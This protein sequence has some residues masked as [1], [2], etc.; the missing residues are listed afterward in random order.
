[1][2]MRRWRQVGTA[3]PFLLG[4]GVGLVPVALFIPASLVRAPGAASFLETVTIWLFLFGVLPA[5][6]ILSLVSFRVPRCLYSTLGLWMAVV[7]TPLVLIIYVVIWITFFASAQDR[8]WV[9]Y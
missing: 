8:F 9:F 5:A 3:H 6:V 7:S 1:M 2:F 4:L